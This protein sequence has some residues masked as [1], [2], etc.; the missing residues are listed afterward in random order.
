MKRCSI[1]CPRNP[2]FCADCADESLDA[3]V[4]RLAEFIMKNVPGEPSENEGAIDTA[5][6]VLA[7]HYPTPIS[8][9]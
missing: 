4:E 8:Q 9:S 6:R 1:G 7:K 2:E 5:I 3:Q